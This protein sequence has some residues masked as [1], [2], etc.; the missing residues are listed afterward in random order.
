MSLLSAVQIVGLWSMTG[1]AQPVPEIAQDSV[2]VSPA[3]DS[4]ED[5]ED[6]PKRI[7]K[8]EAIVFKEVKSIPYSAG[9][10][11]LDRGICGAFL[12]GQHKNRGEIGSLYQWQGEITYYYTPWFSGGFGFRIKAGEPSDSSQK[13]LNRYFLLT[14]FHKVFDNSS[15]YIGPQLGLDNL[16][17]LNGESALS[18]SSIKHVVINRLTGTNASLGL[19]MGGG[20]KFSRWMGATLGSNVEFSFVG[21]DGLEDNSLNL[22]LNPGFAVDILAFT[23]SLREL[24]PALYVNVEFQMGF[25]LLEKKSKQNDRAAILGIGL[26]F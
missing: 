24:V 15:F 19:E 7:P 4:S 26:A 2:L 10:L 23:D 11:H 8:V 22:H 17:V 21:E 16:N 9:A 3:V 13:I 1:F 12:G 5:P 25:L 20:W 14:R 18:D 6:E